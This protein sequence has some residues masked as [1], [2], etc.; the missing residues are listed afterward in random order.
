[1]SDDWEGV[2][3]CHAECP[4]QSGGEPTPDFLRVEAS[5]VPW[6]AYLHAERSSA[7]D[8]KGRDR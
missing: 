7:S 4:C 3:T 6:L 5:L 1:M 8:E 2:H